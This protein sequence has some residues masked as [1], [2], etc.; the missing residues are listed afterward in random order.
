M[1]RR[2]SEGLLRAFDCELVAWPRAASELVPFLIKEAAAGYSLSCG[3][4][5]PQA[6]LLAD[7][8]ENNVR[9]RVSMAPGQ[10]AIQADSKIC[11]CA[12][13]TRG[14]RPSRRTASLLQR[15]QQARFV[16]PADP[17]SAFQQLCGF[18][19]VCEAGD[20]IQNDS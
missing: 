18:L 10:S 3:V 16:L 20:L 13:L 8:A 2:E 4:C 9:I 19:P 15:Q 1:L 14:G 5:P 12:S 7:A 17:C 6:E 11:G